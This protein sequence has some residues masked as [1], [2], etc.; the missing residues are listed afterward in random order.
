MG[1]L[2]YHLP[3]EPAAYGLNY[4]LEKDLTESGRPE[5]HVV[6]V[7]SSFYGTGSARPNW[8]VPSKSTDSG[9]GPLQPLFRQ[10][11]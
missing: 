4:Y 3:L 10:T 2:V 5:A 7:I 8:T 11:R 9:S 6:T 1:C